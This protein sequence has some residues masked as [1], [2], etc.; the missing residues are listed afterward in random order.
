VPISQSQLIGRFDLLVFG[1]DGVTIFDWKTDARPRPAA[2]LSQDLQSRLYLALVVEGS[3]AWGEA[4]SADRV[5]LTY[6]F[7]N[8]PAATVT[9]PYNQAQ[10]E[11][12]WADLLDMVGEIES[13]LVAQEKWLLTGDLAQCEHCAY[14]VYCG[15]LVVVQDPSSWQEE[16]MAIQLEPELP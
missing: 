10:H 1:E 11:R 6:W 15:R 4:I 12:N 16:N 5:R 9:I 7:V 14:T 2:E 13:Q 8:D 3:T